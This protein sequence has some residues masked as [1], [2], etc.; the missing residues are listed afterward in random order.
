MHFVVKFHICLFYYLAT[1][2]MLELCAAG[3]SAACG[4]PEYFI[5]IFK[6]FGK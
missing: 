6:I 3:H 5:L 4:F 2:A 1:V